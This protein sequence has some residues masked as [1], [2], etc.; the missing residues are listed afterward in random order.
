MSRIRGRDTSPEVK[1]RH[2]IWRLG[3]R[4]R[5]NQRVAGV[6]PDIIFP[7]TRL[8]VFVDCCFWHGCPDHY[9][10]PR[11]SNAEFW[12]LK[13]SQN[14]ARDERQL[15]NL[16]AE[17]W[18]VIRVWE[19]EIEDNLTETALLIKRAARGEPVIPAERWVVMGAAPGDLAGQE[20]WTLR[21]L[22][23]GRVQQVSHSRGTDKRRKAGKLADRLP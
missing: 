10:R 19:H 15:G 11:S 6:R 21:D 13:L 2:A 9:V 18:R 1:L 4:Y 8:A 5:L 20:Q 12:A 16:R 3:M 7:G 17:G 14:V 23:S 22:Y